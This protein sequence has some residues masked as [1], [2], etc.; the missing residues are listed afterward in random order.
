M[1]ESIRHCQ[2]QLCIPSLSCTSW[3]TALTF[4]SQPLP[5]AALWQLAYPQDSTVCPVVLLLCAYPCESPSPAA[6]PPC[7]WPSSLQIQP[8]PISLIAPDLSS[9]ATCCKLSMAQMAQLAGSPPGGGGCSAAVMLAS[10]MTPVT[11]SS[12]C[13]TCSQNWNLAWGG[14][15]L[16]VVT[17]GC[18]YGQ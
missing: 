7:W 18:S 5:E 9:W 15:M 2:G 10:F 8:T 1:I 17:Q 4:C 16:S 6:V 13:Q 3:L 11:P 14:S 12:L